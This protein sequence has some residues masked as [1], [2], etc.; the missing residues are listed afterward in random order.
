MK[1]I[2][3]LKTVEPHKGANLACIIKKSLPVRKAAGDVVVEKVTNTCV[4]TGVTYDN[5][6]N[7]QEKRESG[8]LPAENAG[9]LWGEWKVFNYVKTHKGDKYFRLYTGTNKNFVPTT[10]YY[11]DGVEVGRE[12]VEPICTKAAFPSSSGRDCF[13]VK[14]ENLLF[15]GLSAE[16]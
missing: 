3:F 16:Q 15:I 11:L 14:Q 2:E 10:H 4:R 9:L 5:I 1:E 6:K 8:E 7:V 12:V 13:D